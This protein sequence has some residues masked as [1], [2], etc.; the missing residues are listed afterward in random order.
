MTKLELIKYLEEFRFKSGLGPVSRQLMNQDI[1]DLAEYLYPLMHKEPCEVCSSDKYLMEKDFLDRYII[2]W[3]LDMKASEL[4][5]STWVVMFD[6]RGYLRLASK[7]DHNCLD[8]GE[9]YKT[10]HCF[11]CGRKLEGEEE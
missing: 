9:R 5:L 8:N 11:N 4:N 10:K 7:D 6:T 1:D 3:D 2:G